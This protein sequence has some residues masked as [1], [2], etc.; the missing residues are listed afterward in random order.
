MAEEH[1]T[2]REKVNTPKWKGIVYLIL[3][4]IC[5]AIVFISKNTLK[6]LFSRK[7]APDS[8]LVASFEGYSEEELKMEKTKTLDLFG[9][10]ASQ[11]V[12]VFFCILILFAY[13][14]VKILKID[15]QLLKG[16]ITNNITLMALAILVLVFLD[17]ILP[18]F[19]FWF[20]NKVIR[21]R[22]EIFRADG[23]MGRSKSRKA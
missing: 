17:E 1:Q 13:I 3:V 12:I 23:V 14:L 22:T 8:P 7:L 16:L 2:E 9:Y 10:K 5:N 11:N 6:W 20:L 21:F 15:V 4:K 19:I 18:R